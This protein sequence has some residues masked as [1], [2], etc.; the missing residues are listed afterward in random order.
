MPCRRWTGSDDEGAE[1][2]EPDKASAAFDEGLD[3]MAW[4]QKKT[5]AAPADAGD[6]DSD[7]D[8]KSEDEQAS[9]SVLHTTWR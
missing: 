6:S 7:D 9:R 4:L 2:A 8:D 5:S 1:P 3:D